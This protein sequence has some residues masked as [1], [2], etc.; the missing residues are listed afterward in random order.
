MKNL[1]LL[2]YHWFIALFK[3]KKIITEPV[4]AEPETLSDKLDKLEKKH[5]I[6]PSGPRHPVHNNRK[7]THYRYTQYTP[8]GRA[9]F[10]E[11]RTNKPSV[12]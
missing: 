3:S 1:L 9:I 5:N 6:H 10:H 11:G 7:N 8:E 12:L 2:I 4:K